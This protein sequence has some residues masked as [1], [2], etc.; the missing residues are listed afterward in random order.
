MFEPVHNPRV[1]ILGGYGN[2]G[3][4]VATLLL[5]D[6]NLEVIL[7]GRDITKAQQE[8]AR[9]Q[10]QIPHANITPLQLDWRAFDFKEKLKI[11]APHL[12][13]HSAGPF[14]AQDYSVVYACID[15]KIHYIDLSDAR[16]FVTGII[17]L[18]ELAKQQD[19]VV[20]SGASS[21]PGLSSVIIDSYATKYTEL[22]EIDFGI[23]P[24]NKAERGSATI[25]AILSYTGKPFMRLE[26][27][28]WKKVYGWQ[29][30]HRHYYGDN[31]GLRLHGNLDIP[32]LDL[33]PDRYPMLKTVTFH[34]GLEVPLLHWIMWHMSWLTRAKIVKDWSAFVKPINKLSHWFDNWGT[35]CGGMF[36]HL[37]GSNH[38][39]QPL[40]IYWTLVADKGHG[41]YLPVIPSVI[42][43]HKILDNLVPA[44]ARPCLGLFTLAEFD[45][46]IKD[47]DIYYTVQEVVS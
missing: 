47:W 37:S 5:K 45:E 42:M 19:V 13:I 1:L 28:R 9:L 12:L 43:A 4:R 26:N 41:P 35:D 46:Q 38:D 14:Q 24:G 16:E 15:L 39:Y 44:G 32:D 6:P 27:G 8:V 7:A 29:N 23:A 20:L 17:T 18:D 36:I 30:L 21:V 33:L 34:A 11:A 10:Q 25:E 22:R 31:I 3:K 2:F 40:D